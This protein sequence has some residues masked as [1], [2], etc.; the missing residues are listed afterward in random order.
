MLLSF[1][2][3][4]FTCWKGSETEVLDGH[5]KSESKQKEI[6]AM[7]DVMNGIH[8]RPKRAGGVVVPVAFASPSAAW[9]DDDSFS[10]LCGVLYR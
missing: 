1:F 5:E 2:L 8:Q 4:F 9:I 3:S 6:T 7:R 10:G